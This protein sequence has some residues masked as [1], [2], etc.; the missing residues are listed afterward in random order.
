MRPINKY[1]MPSD[2]DQDDFYK[3]ILNETY[4][5]N[6]LPETILQAVK[7]AYKLGYQRCANLHFV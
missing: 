5:E 7:L 3:E 1:P 4:G 2:K 6:N